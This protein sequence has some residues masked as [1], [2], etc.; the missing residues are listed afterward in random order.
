MIVDYPLRNRLYRAHKICL[1]WARS[2]FLGLSNRLSNLGTIVNRGGFHG[3]L[4]EDASITAK[5]IYMLGT[6]SSHMHC[7]HCDGSI[8]THDVLLALRP[9]PF[10]TSQILMAEDADGNPLLVHESDYNPTYMRL[11]DGKKYP[12]LR[13]IPVFG[14]DY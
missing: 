4:V 13:R 3:V 10:G 2:A 5:R 14:E 8:P 9:P 1:D 12:G 6:D 7:P 11:V